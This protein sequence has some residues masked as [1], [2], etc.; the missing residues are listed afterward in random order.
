MVL[1]ED[2]KTLENDA[3]QW[4]IGNHLKRGFGNESTRGV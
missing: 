2:I 4:A 1:R 3:I